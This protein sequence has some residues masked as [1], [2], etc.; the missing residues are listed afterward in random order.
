MLFKAIIIIGD[1]IIRNKAKSNNVEVSLSEDDMS[2]TLSIIH[3]GSSLNIDAKKVEGLS[4][5]LHKLRN[6]LLNI[7][8][9]TIEADT[10]TL[11]SIRI[12][13]L[14]SNTQYAF[15]NNKDSVITA[16]TY[17]P[18]SEPIGGVKYLIKIYKNI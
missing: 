13:Y 10:T 12:I 15:T 11:G 8:D 17:N 2:Y 1:W 5:D 4:G 14:D 18:I 6:T 7:S 9:L 16:A 3:K